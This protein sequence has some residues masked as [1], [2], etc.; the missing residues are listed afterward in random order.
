M[1]TMTATDF[2]KNIKGT[3]DR[4][5]FGGEEIIITRNKRQIA[6]ILPGSHYM[7]ALEAMADLYRILPC[8]AADGW[9]EESRMPEKV[10][11]EMSD[12]WD[13]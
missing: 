9:L 3:L 6:R 1:A 5:E 10:A 7:T 13:S 8:D 12:P 2:A 11:R 4:L